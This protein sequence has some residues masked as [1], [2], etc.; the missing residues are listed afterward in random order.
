M[1]QPRIGR[2]WAVGVG[3]GD[4]ELLTLKAL[5]IVQQ[6]AVV[7]H[8]GQEPRRGRAYEIVS[9]HLRPEQETRVV[10][11]AAMSEVNDDNWRTHYRPG[12]EQIAAD[13]RAGRDVA[14]LTEGDP[15]IY[16]TGACVWQLLAEL[17][18]DIDIEIVPGVSSVT[19]AAAGVGW[20]LAQRGEAFVV[21]P[22]SYHADELR[23][24]VAEFPTVCLLKP[25]ATLPRLVEVLNEYG[26]SREAVYVENLGSGQEWLTTDLTQAA[27]RRCY[28]ASV[29]VRT[30]P[31]PSDSEGGKHPSPALRAS[32]VTVV[33]LGPGDPELLTSRART[34][35]RDAEVIVG[36]EAYLQSLA[37]LALRAELHGS[38]IGAEV[39]RAQHALELTQAG[40]RVALVSSGDAGVYGMASVLLEAAEHFP[41]LSVEVVPGVTAVLA[42]AALLGAPLGH[43]F[44]CISLSD[45]LTNW[46][47]IATKLEAAADGD[48]VL[49]LYNPIS[50]QRTWQ[51]AK[52]RD[53]LLNHRRPG[54]PVGFVDRAFR[55][56]MRVWLTTL[57]EWAASDVGMETT[58]IIG[59][60]QTRI[61]NGR[62]VTPRG[63]KR[64]EA[65]RGRKPPE[66]VALAVGATSSGGL[67]PPLAIET[68]LRIYEES[69][70]IIERELGPHPLPPWAFAALRRMIHASADFEYAQTLRYSADFETVIGSALLDKAPIVTDT[71]M[72]LLGIR[73]VLGRTPGFCVAC[74]LNDPE[75]T[76]LAAVAGITRTAAGIRRAAQKHPRPVLVIG[77]APTALD[78]ALRLIEEGTWRP[79]VIIGMPVGFVGVLEAKGRL[80]EQTRVPYLTCEG[81]KGGSAVAAAAVNALVEWFRAQV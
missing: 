22:A 58:I 72:V 36:Y 41:E 54:T 24:W 15:T 70:A 55:P 32:T 5:R 35:L 16:S 28:F 7:Y 8:A 40:R 42:A 59:N 25:G 23:R 45:L 51:L 49:A 19:A 20:P 52:A 57:G 48:F 66:D 69:F 39:D 38:P 65:S 44:A 71:K 9:R 13:C 21:A 29:I 81:R 18:P 37:P 26:P 27:A 56:G 61:V 60:S 73:T 17:D 62:M 46:D 30:P 64:S 74:H 50:K 47:V 79:A 1:D 4:P 78:E 68:A 31:A 6:V 3:P 67:R 80:L 76:E 10:L 43:D 75:T 2:F 33:G 34:I 63:Y 14:F 11:T 53:I 12:V 77:N